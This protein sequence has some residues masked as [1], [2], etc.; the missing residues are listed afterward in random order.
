MRQFENAV[1]DE[2]DNAVSFGGFV[3]RNRTHP[4]PASPNADRACVRQTV[5]VGEF[6]RANSSI[7][8]IIQIDELR[9]SAA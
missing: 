2:S 8:I 4:N 9:N 5:A 3:A 7:S 6:W 1:F